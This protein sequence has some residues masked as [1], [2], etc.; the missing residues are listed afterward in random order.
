ML[1]VAQSRLN[2]AQEYWTTNHLTTFKDYLKAYNIADVRPFICAF[3][4]FAKFFIRRKFDV[5]R[6][7][8]LPSI[9][10]EYGVRYSPPG[11]Y[12]VRFDE[13][14]KD[15]Y[16]KIKSNLYG[17]V[18]LVWN[19]YVECNKTRIRANEVASPELVQSITGLDMSGCYL[20]ATSEEHMIGPYFERKAENDFRIESQFEALNATL[21]VEWTAFRLGGA[22]A[23]NNLQHMWKGGEKRFISS[24]LTSYRVDGYTEFNNERVI[25][26][27][28]GCWFHNHNPCRL[29][30]GFNTWAQCRA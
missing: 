5:F 30:N 29:I 22:E 13:N 17:G 21:A 15:C 23:L 26:E 14:G 12:F 2:I 3:K 19:R 20:Q 6:H 28:N 18:S 25:I 7:I 16:N 24:R 4:E 1:A 10:K 8:T 11:S 9:A 27:Y